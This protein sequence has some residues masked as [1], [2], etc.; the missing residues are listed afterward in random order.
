MNTPTVQDPSIADA[1]TSAET[2][3]SAED[4]AQIQSL[5]PRF[6]G[7]HALKW[8]GGISPRLGQ[9]R[10]TRLLALPATGPL[11]ALLEQRS[12]Q[13]VKALRTYAAINM[14]QAAAALRMTVIVN[15]S[16]P[17]IIVAILSQISSGEIWAA[18]WSLYTGDGVRWI[19]LVA[20]IIIALAILMMILA[21]G[22][23]RLGQA[24]DIRHL[25]DLIAADRGIYFGLDDAD[26]LLPQ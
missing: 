21:T 11:A 1:P 22:A 18:Y 17:V 15:V 14:E 4:W 8:V 20:P 2:P 3:T 25:I 23:T 5:F 19:A 12:S 13:R 6:G 24:R 10:L 9:H 7:R 16:I 26:N